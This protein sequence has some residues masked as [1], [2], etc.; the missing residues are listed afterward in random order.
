[1]SKDLKKILAP[2][3]KII[4][5]EITQSLSRFGSETDLYKACEYVLTNGGKRFRP[6]IVMMV[7]NALTAKHRVVEAALA[8]EYFHTASLIADDLPSMDNEEKRRD[9]ETVHRKFGEASALLASYALI[10]AGYECLARNTRYLQQ[11]DHPLAEKIG[12]LALENATF[13]TGIH[14]ATGGQFLDLFPPQLSQEILLETTQKK[15]VSLFEIAMVLGWLFGGG[16]LSKL[17]LVKKASYHYGMAFQIADDIDDYETD[18]VEKRQMNVIHFLGHEKTKSLFHEEIAA[19]FQCLS[20]LDIDTEE[21]H[22]LG[23]YLVEQ[24]EKK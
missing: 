22:S 14:G 1:M 18:T 24:V 2:Y 13:N 9:K 12:I 5:S 21:L 8:I 17:P 3:Q 6:A 16:N 10:A 4:E 23:D 15:T 20:E 7:A 11:V 19:F